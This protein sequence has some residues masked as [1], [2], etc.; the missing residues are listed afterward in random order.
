M[1]HVLSFDCFR[2][3]DVTYRQIQNSYNHTTTLVLLR[4]RRSDT[5]A[6]ARMDH[7]LLTYLLTYFM[8]AEISLTYACQKQPVY[9]KKRKF[10]RESK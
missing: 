5:F 10:S 4:L 7:V 1:L 2:Q 6:I 9:Q 8:L 3:P